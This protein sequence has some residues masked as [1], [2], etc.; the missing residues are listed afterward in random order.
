MLN[1]VIKTALKTLL[2]VI[3]ALLVAFAIASLGFPASMATLFENWGDYSTATGYASLNYSYTKKPD[4]LA[5]CV[6]DS[7]I[8]KNDNDII[9]YGEQFI[10]LK[11]FDEVCARK[12]EEYKLSFN[13]LVYGNLACAKYRQGYK[14][15]ALKYAKDGYAKVKEEGFIP[16][17]AIAQLSVQVAEK[18]DK[19]TAEKLLEEVNSVTFVGD[20]NAEYYEA[21]K[22]VLTKTVEKA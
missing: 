2:G 21:V 15:T 3:I 8:S 14:E 6:Q 13:Q 4:D 22:S 12:S 9:K 7:I 1:I 17:N 16:G 20:G 10:E 11:E 18:S 19:A 5:R